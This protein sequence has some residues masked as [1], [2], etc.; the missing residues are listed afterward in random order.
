MCVY[1]MCLVC[2]CVSLSTKSMMRVVVSKG[3]SYVHVY[4]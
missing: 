1:S 4:V 2:M 3:F